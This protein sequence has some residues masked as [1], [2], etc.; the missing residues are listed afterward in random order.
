V[1]NLEGEEKK[2]ETFIVSMCEGVE[3]LVWSVW[4]IIYAR[5]MIPSWINGNFN[6]L[7][8]ILITKN[9]IDR[10]TES[11][12]RLLIEEKFVYYSNNLY[13]NQTRSFS[14]RKQQILT[15]SIW[16]STKS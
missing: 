6:G 2:R 7:K 9:I 15:V 8:N 1:K 11:F 12:I 4:V 16:Y 13:F 3:C 14:K 5:R 10:K